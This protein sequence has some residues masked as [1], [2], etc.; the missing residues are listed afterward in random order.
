MSSDAFADLLQ[1][2]IPAVIPP[3][4]SAQVSIVYYSPQCRLQDDGTLTGLPDAV[5]H[6]STKERLTSVRRLI[7]L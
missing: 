2:T 7:R 3:E 5:A 1:L 6:A 4:S